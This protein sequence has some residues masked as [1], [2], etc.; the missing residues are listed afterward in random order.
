MAAN[1]SLLIKPDFRKEEFI[2]VT[3]KTAG[4]DFL[5]FSAVKLDERKSWYKNTDDNELAVVIFGGSARVETKDIS[6]DHVGSRK[7]VFNGMPSSV[8]VPKN[9]QIR[10]TAETEGLEFGVGWCKAINDH[11][12]KLITPE[13]V[14]VEIRGGG[15]ATRQIN[16]MILPGFDCDKLVV[17]E[18]YT[19][20]GNWSS[21]PPHKH[22]TR[23]FDSA[24]RLLEA[25]LEEIYYYKMDRPE[26]FAYQRIYTE[27]RRL[28]ELIMVHN[29]ELVLSPEGYHPVVAA[30]GYNVYYLNML[31]GSD[32]SLASSDDPLYAWV[33]TGWDYIDPRLPLVNL[34]MN[35]S[36][37]K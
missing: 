12:A 11:P 14:R 15:N 9:N 23:K 17:V 21:Y 5:N 37:I 8:F 28:D 1:K 27:D 32:Q 25:D 22:D 20:S 3:P 30:H 34:E 19:P 24:G 10:I 13:E 36:R 18:V 2:Q 35:Q 7:D 4:W 16:Q 29:N 6:W 26:G 33:K 31:A